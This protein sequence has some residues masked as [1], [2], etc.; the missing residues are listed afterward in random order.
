MDLVIH[1]AERGSV[2]FA[3]IGGP[4]VQRRTY[5]LGEG[6]APGTVPTEDELEGFLAQLYD[7]LEAFLEAT[8]VEDLPEELDTIWLVTHPD[9][10]R[11]G[12]VL[13]QALAMSV[14]QQTEAPVRAVPL[15]TLPED[16]SA[17]PRACADA[18]LL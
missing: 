5:P 11:V 13:A 12:V 3:W 15:D 14:Q 6:Q 2:V 16:W 8:G 7:H 9:G 4:L 10:P 17:L 18:P 1:A